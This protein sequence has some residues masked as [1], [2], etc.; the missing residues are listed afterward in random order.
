MSGHTVIMQEG[1]LLQPETILS[2]YRPIVLT[3]T[4][5]TLQMHDEH[6]LYRP[7]EL[8]LMNSSF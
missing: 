4:L 6:V 1:L 3:V 5:V 8:D 2:I 7:Q